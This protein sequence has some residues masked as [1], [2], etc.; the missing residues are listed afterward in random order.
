MNK[1]GQ[2]SSLVHF[3]HIVPLIDIQIESHD[4]FIVKTVH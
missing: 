1:S 3:R 2:F 4:D